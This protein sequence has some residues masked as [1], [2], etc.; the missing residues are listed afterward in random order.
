MADDGHV[1]LSKDTEK[2]AVCTQG[3]CRIIFGGHTGVEGLAEGGGG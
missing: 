1:V 3:R 2:E